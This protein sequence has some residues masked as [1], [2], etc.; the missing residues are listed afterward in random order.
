MFF[1]SKKVRVV[2]FKTHEE[3]SRLKIFIES[4]AIPKYRKV[5]TNG[6]KRNYIITQ[7]GSSTSECF[8][9]VRLRQ[10]EIMAADYADLVEGALVRESI[11]YG[12]EVKYIPSRKWKRM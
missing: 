7:Q 2:E 1:I 10:G 6:S 3:E 4:L 9:K 8:G 12:R 11:I 5:Q